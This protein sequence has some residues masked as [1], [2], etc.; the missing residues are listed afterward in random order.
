MRDGDE[1]IIDIA[2]QTGWASLGAFGRTF[3][4]ITG[5]SPTELR[6]KER[7]S[8]NPMQAVPACYL[9]AARRPDLKIAVSEKRRL[10]AADIDGATETEVP[11]ETP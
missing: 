8:G 10:E 5:Q 9:I 3:R 1:P 7:A 6:E 4:D 11:R 2:F